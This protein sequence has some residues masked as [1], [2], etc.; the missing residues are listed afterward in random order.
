M[1]KIIIRKSTKMLEVHFENIL[2]KYPDLIEPGLRLLGRQETLRGKRVDLLFEDANNGRLVVEVKI[3]A[4]SRADFGQVAEYCH[5]LHTF[6]G[7]KP[8]GML[9]GTRVPDEV[10]STAQYLGLECKAIS[11]WELYEAME[12]YD[13]REMLAFINLPNLATK[14]KV[15][16]G[17]AIQLPT[18]PLRPLPR[19]AAPPNSAP[20]VIEALRAR[21]RCVSERSEGNIDAKYR[22]AFAE[23]E[24]GTVVK[25]DEIW[26]IMERRFSGQITTGGIL[27]QDRC[28]N[29]TNAGLG[30]NR[31]FRIFE[32]IGRAAFRYL[33]ES[34]RYTGAVTWK[35]VQ[36]GQW[37]D[38][39]LTKF[40]NW[41]ELKAARR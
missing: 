35:D 10:H 13:D 9:I 30:P 14:P 1:L 16:E 3:G 17:K 31:D 19:R 27:P 24:I 4:V 18:L 12:A 20:K 37:E 21:T 11:L 6:S 5:Y 38:G 32:Y 25:R 36:C 26:A 28:Y 7:S 22:T 41:P 8:R 33:G 40:D 29:I 2:A 15:V 23:V 34:Y 39:V